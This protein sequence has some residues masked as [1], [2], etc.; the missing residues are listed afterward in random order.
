[1]KSLRKFWSYCLSIFLRD[2]FNSTVEIGEPISRFVVDLKKISVK[3]NLARPAAFKPRKEERD[4][5]VYRIKNCS[6][7]LIWRV[8][9]IFVDLLRTGSK[10]TLA[11]ADFNI[12]LL[13]SKKVL[14]LNF[15][16]RPYKRHLNI[17]NWPDDSYGKMISTELSKNSKLYRKPLKKY[18]KLCIEKIFS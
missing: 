3:K 2:N 15:D 17:E 18:L 7:S 4:L 12:D 9:V 14:F 13:T 8:S 1:M 10:K 5:S 6:D 16:G 11:R